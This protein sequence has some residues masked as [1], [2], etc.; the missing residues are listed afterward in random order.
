MRN[1]YICSALVA[2]FGAA[3]HMIPRDDKTKIISEEE[4]GRITPRFMRGNQFE[5]GDGGPDATYRMDDV[6]YKVL[7][8]PSAVC[9]VFVDGGDSYDVV[10]LSSRSKDAFHDPNICFSAQLWSIE[11]REPTTFMTKTRGKMPITIISMFNQTVRRQLAA[12]IYKGPGGY[13]SDTNKLKLA[14]LKEELMMGSNLDGVFYRFIPTFKEQLPEDQQRKKLLAFIS[15]YMDE[16]NKT[17][18]GRL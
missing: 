4:L 10:V 8:Y 9:R 12:Y 5:R 7:E 3:I 13:Y 16:A 14:F 2:L 17:S 11:K 1:V 6:S 18:K 15:E